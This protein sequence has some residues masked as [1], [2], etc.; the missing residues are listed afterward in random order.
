MTTKILDNQICTFKILLSWRFSQKKTAFWMIVLSAPRAPPS[1]S[2]KV[3][4]YCRL[5]VSDS[6]QRM[7]PAEGV[8]EK[9]HKK[10]RG[11]RARDIQKRSCGIVVLRI[12]TCKPLRTFLGSI[13]H[14]GLPC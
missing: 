4:F 5:A 13:C 1:N 7:R 12:T 2:E 8:T 14:N 10:R 9:Q 11:K 6:K 3:Y